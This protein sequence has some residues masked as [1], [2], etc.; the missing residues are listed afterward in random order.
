MG[1]TPNLKLPYPD[2]TDPISPAED[3]ENFV[4][5]V[6]EK[7]PFYYAARVDYVSKRVAKDTGSFQHPFFLDT[8][9]K[10]P[11]ASEPSGWDPGA[12][13]SIQYRAADAAAKAAARKAA[14][15]AALQRKIEQRRQAAAAAA[16]KAAAAHKQQPYLSN[17]PAR[18]RVDTFKGNNSPNHY[19]WN[20]RRG[21]FGQYS[22]TNGNQKC[23]VI[24]DSG[25]LS[26]EHR[27]ARADITRIRLKFYVEHTFAFSG[28][29][30]RIQPVT[31]G[32]PGP[33]PDGGAPHQDVHVPHSG[34]VTVT[35]NSSLL[36]WLDTSM[37]PKF[38]GFF[39]SAVSGSRNDYGYLDL[40]S[41]KMFVDWRT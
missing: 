20:H 11:P 21:Y 25:F 6:D 35:L 1:E 30:V 14:Q 10:A 40:K 34:W 22:G 32:S 13:N 15:A 19:G 12:P 23:M 26:H 29:T 17:N 18:N 31:N 37:G 33:H 2:G 7:V 5:A 27:A 38:T 39:F 41:V 9:D 4:E 16:A 8:W 3:I 36:H 28:G 24:F